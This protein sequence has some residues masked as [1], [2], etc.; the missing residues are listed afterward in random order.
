MDGGLLCLKW[1]DHRSTFFRMLSSV[2]KKEVYCDATIAC[3]G[4][5]YPVH[6]LVLST[7]SEYFERMFEVAD[8]Q[9]LMIVLA[10]IQR[11]DLETLLDYMY[12][13]EVNVLQSDLSGFMK[14]AERLKIKG[15][16]EP[17][18]T[19]TRKEGVDG[20]R[21]LP[22][23]EDNWEVKRRKQND[24]VPPYS[25]AEVKT[26]PRGSSPTKASKESYNEP[27]RG[28]DQTAGLG[29]T[30]S[31]VTSPTPGIVSPAQL[32]SAELGAETRT[33]SGPDPLPA[34]PRGPESTVSHDGEVTDCDSTQVKCEDIN[35]KEEPEDWP[36]T[37][38]NEESQLFRFADPGLTYLANTSTLPL[39]TQGQA[40]PLDH[41]AH[42]VPGPSGLHSAVGWEHQTL[43]ASDDFV[44][45]R[46]S[47]IKGVSQILSEQSQPRPVD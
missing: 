2:R 8:K 25:K 31:I 36:N 43:T 40:G 34:V 4:R 1:R 7:C 30:N 13:G 29:K 26:C 47:P 3:D 12:I 46:D 17:T 35:V 23:K 5:F 20:K 27:K 42:P 21:S 37:E 14:A 39:V 33:D 32:A 22:Q 18:D 11:E 41:P 38:S 44:Q 6:R 15:L 10:D 28:R 19:I 24:E 16:A 45:Y 9:H